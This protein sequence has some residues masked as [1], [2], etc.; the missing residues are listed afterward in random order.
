[1]D[2]IGIMMIEVDVVGTVVVSTIIADVDEV[3]EASSIE[4][5]VEWCRVLVPS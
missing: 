4:T 5:L 1:M 3:V 2:K